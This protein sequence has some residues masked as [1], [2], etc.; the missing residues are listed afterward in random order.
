MGY[1]LIGDLAALAV[2]LGRHEHVATAAP[3][4]DVGATHR[5]LYQRRVPGINKVPRAYVASRSDLGMASHCWLW[6]PTSLPVH[7]RRQERR[8]RRPSNGDSLPR[9]ALVLKTQ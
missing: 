1:G 3:A 5:A 7:A 6:D 9:Q 2:H 4:L 8:M